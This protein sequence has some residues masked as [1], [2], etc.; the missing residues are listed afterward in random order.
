MAKEDFTII[1][2]PNEIKLSTG[3]LV[4]LRERKGQHHIIESRL[5]SNC[6]MTTQNAGI[7]IGDLI[8][9]AE[10]KLA[11]SVAEVD[12]KPIKMPMELKDV[13][14]LASLFQYEEW[15]ELKQVLQPKKAATEA[16]AKNLAARDGSVKE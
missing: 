10:I 15:D 8:L 3:K 2:N 4:L 5:L 1:E 12:G 11:V 9:A 16:E 13:Y 6:A 14:E 7:N